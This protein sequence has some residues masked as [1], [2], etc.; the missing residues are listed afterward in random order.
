MM[1]AVRGLAP[2]SVR[3][4]V[5]RL[6]A[7]LVRVR[8]RNE[9]RRLARSGR[10]VITGPWLG[11]VGFELL[12]WVPFLRWA[13]DRFGLAPSRVV[14][15]SRGG[16]A[17]WYDGLAARYVDVFDVVGV[18][19]FRAGNAARRAELGE[20]KQ[21]RCTAFD[22]EVIGRVR[23]AVSIADAEVLHPSLMYRSV[24]AYW[25]SHAPLS[26]V[27]GQ[28]MYEKLVA[29]PLPPDL[30]VSPG[31]YVAVKFYA[32]DC[33][34]GGDD[35]RRYAHAVTDA[36]AQCGP[37]VSLSTHLSLDDHD[38]S[39]AR[40]PTVAT[41]KQQVTARNNLEVQTAVVANASAFVGTYGG[42]S[43]LAPLCGMSAIAMYAHAD[44]FDASHLH[45]ART[46]AVAIGAPPFHARPLSDASPEW[47]VS[48]VHGEGERQVV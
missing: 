31:R 25:W 42:F 20:Q 48:T 24:Q 40:A 7:E 47:V 41:V 10:P 13:R 30:G 12:Y 15:T 28:A 39:T 17:G 16:A 26:W 18:E 11:E 32:N 19:E 5:G 35:G 45:V 27:T 33:F 23:E 29:S 2:R 38:E 44:Q 46:A 37:V 43:Y 6:R 22:R 1:N 14:A 21:V 36:L 9:L 34:P 8:V 3:R 4:R